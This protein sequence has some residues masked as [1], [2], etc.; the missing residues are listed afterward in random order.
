M[1]TYCSLLAVRRPMK[2]FCTPLEEAATVVIRLSGIIG[3]SSVLGFQGEGGGGRLLQMNRSA[4]S[5]CSLSLE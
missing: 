1:A 2:K 4:L 5:S 3:H